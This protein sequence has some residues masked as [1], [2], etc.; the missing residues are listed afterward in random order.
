MNLFGPDFLRRCVRGENFTNPREYIK[1]ATLK[2]VAAYRRFGV[3]DD[4][5][6]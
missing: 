6:L 4:E 2:T 3:F 1:L 5:A